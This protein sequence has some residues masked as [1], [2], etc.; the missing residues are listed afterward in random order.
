MNAFV[1]EFLSAAR[2]S[3]R[4]FFAPLIGAINGTRE[5]IRDSV[6]DARQEM[7]R[8]KHEERKGGRDEAD[9]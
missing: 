4:L 5:A 2:E 8:R 3:P 9:S 7:E 1:R 6:E